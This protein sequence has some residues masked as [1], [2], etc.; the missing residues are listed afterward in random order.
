M[1]DYDDNRVEH[2][3]YTEFIADL[4]RKENEN[5]YSCICTGSILSYWI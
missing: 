1:V 3:M 5:N 2:I 4:N